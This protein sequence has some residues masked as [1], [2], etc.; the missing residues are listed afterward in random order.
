MSHR[1]PD[2]KH[3]GSSVLCGVFRARARSAL[4]PERI[5]VWKCGVEPKHSE[6]EG[7]NVY[8]KIYVM[9]Q[10]IMRR[11]HNMAK[12][13]ATMTY[14]GCCPRKG[15]QN[16]GGWGGRLSIGAWEQNKKRLLVEAG[17]FQ[18]LQWWQRK[19]MMPQEKDESFWINVWC[20]VEGRRE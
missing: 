1:E 9:T 4:D 17:V 15:T 6:E 16:G 12:M 7:S 18:R 14:F 20:K 11:I 5:F 2:D 13:A 3:K 8:W 19:R 10:T